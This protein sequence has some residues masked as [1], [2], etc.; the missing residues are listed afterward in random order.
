M[1]IKVLPIFPKPQNLKVLGVD[2]NW[3][4]DKC[5]FHLS[6]LHTLCTLPTLLSY[7]SHH[8]YLQK[9]DFD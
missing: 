4:V 6:S 5:K 7:P 1:L 2:L 9:L 8:K 3:L